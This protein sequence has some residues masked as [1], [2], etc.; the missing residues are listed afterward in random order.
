VG[1]ED[2]GSAW[3]SDGNT[4]VL[5][6][7]LALSLAGSLVVKYGELA[8]DFPF[9]AAPTAALAMVLIPSALNIL[10]WKSRSEE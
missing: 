7:L 8:V 2:V 1:W 5:G 3:K 10:K 6:K 4:A 9:Q